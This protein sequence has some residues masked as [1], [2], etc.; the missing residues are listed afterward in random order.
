MLQG[1]DSYMPSWIDC[2]RSESMSVHAEQ[3][4]SGFDALEYTRSALIEELNLLER[5]MRDGTAFICG[6]AFDSHL[7]MIAGLASEGVKFAKRA[8]ETDFYG[9][10]RDWAHARLKSLED[11]KGLPAETLIR[12]SRER[13]LAIRNGI[14]GEEMSGE[15]IEIA[16]SPRCQFVTEVLKAKGSFDPHS[17]RTICPECPEGDCKLCPAAECSARLVIGCPKGHFVDGRCQIGTEAQK[18]LRPK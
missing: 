3:D 7:P 12:E 8:D 11:V 6:C 15:L 4:T 17:F 14:W 13:R 5:H 1:S 18:I 16:H 10:L 2:T 9:D